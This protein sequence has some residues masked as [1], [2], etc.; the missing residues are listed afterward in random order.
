MHPAVEELRRLVCPPAQ[1]KDAKGDWATC[2][3]ELGLRLPEDYK[4]FITA[5]GRGT[6]CT[7]FNIPSPFTPA[8]PWTKGPIS[9]KEWWAWWA[10][11]YEDWGKTP[12]AMPYQ[13]YPAVPGLLPWAIYGDLDVLSWYTAGE[14]DQWHIVYLHPIEGFWEIPI[15]QGFAE[16]LVAALKGTAPLPER[17]LGRDV[18]E[19]PYEF[20]PY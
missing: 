14:P 9:R 20:Q 16:F 5:Y 4:D 12:R 18:L 19:M 7:L 13:P 8:W 17:T 3:R 2:E 6:L 15:P 11:I 1:P 10:G